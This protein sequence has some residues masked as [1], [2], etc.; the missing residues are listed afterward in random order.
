M[1][2][3]VSSSFLVWC[4]VVMICMFP[5]LVSGQGSSVMAEAQIRANL[6]ATT[7]VGAPLLGEII[8]GTR[9]PV[10]GRSEFYPWILLGDPGTQQPIG[11]VFAELVTIYGDLNTVPFSALVVGSTTSPTSTLAVTAGPTETFQLVGV[12]LPT[13]TLTA[14]NATDVPSTG[15]TGLVTGEINIRYGPGVEYPR[16]GVGRAGDVY[17]IT[18]RHTQLPWVQIRYSGAPNGLGWVA[19]DLLEI[20]GDI[21]SVPSISQTSFDLPT[22]T[23]TPPAVQA[24]SIFQSTPVA[25]TQ[26]FQALGDQLWNMMLEAQFEP[27]TSRLA[28]LF[29]MDLQTEEAITFGNDIAFSGMSLNKIVI[30]AD[31]YS[32]LS[33]PPNLDVAVNIAN[34]MVC[35][36]NSASNALLSYLGNGDP[37]QGAQSVTSFMQ[38]LGLSNTYMVAPFL[39]DPNATP[40]AVRAPDTEADQ[41]RAQPDYSNQLTVD[42]MGWLLSGLYQCAYDGGGPLMSAMPDSYTAGECRQMLDVMSDNNLGQPL[43]M[44]AGVPEDT[45]VAHKHGWTADTHG[46]AGIVFTPGGNYVLVVALHNPVWL[47]FGESFPLITGISRTIYNYYNPDAPMETD[48]EP[49]IVET[50]ECN[51]MGTPILDELTSMN[52]E[53]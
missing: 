6:R 14:V 9:Y 41:I 49:Y 35:S 50:A 20:Q 44:S 11:W 10:I 46:D 39:I 1:I 5:A 43:L 37:Y 22:L 17:D 40:Q 16:I 47:D 26:E 32:Q 42:N 31:L 23:A 36:E 27:E 28:A 25:I 24:S 33:S 53:S 2:K 18:A 3:Y 52:F 48:R 15:V 19:T 8:A 51:V 30:L 29:L 34:M 12:A 13:G 45:R 21:F 4:M 7:D 38:N